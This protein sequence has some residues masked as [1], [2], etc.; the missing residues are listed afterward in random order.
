M[1]SIAIHLG[2]FCCIIFTI[3]IT[4]ELIWIMYYVIPSRELTYPFPSR[5]FWRWLSFS[6]GR[7]ML[8]LWRGI[9]T[10][11]SRRA[12]IASPLISGVVGTLVA[13]WRQQ[14]EWSRSCWEGPKNTSFWKAWDIYIVVGNV[15]EVC[16]VYTVIVFVAIGFTSL[17][18]FFVG[19]SLSIY[20]LRISGANPDRAFSGILASSGGVAARFSRWRPYGK[21][22]GN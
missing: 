2:V 4:H 20:T 10:I 15:W 14:F 3:W 7:D 22:W 17:C 1:I 11:M 16:F 8:V 13:C 5:H 19:A 12:P 9:R 6:P 21:W 18:S